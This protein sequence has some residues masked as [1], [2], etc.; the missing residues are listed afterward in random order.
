MVRLVFS[1]G[2][3]RDVSVKDENIRSIGAISLIGKIVRLTLNFFI[4]SKSMCVNAEFVAWMIVLKKGN[5]PYSYVKLPEG[6]SL[7]NPTPALETRSGS[8]RVWGS[9]HGRSFSRPRDWTPYRHT[10][11]PEDLF[12]FSEPCEA[13]NKISPARDP[14]QYQIQATVAMERG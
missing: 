13:W 10:H 4:C 12:C 5:F 1:L 2:F 3:P 9:P 6:S 11:Q 14:K 8:V 7:C